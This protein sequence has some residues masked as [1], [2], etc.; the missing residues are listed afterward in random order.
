MRGGD[1]SLRSTSSRSVWW[2]RWS[3]NVRIGTGRAS[4]RNRPS[5]GGTGRA[6]GRGLSGG[7]N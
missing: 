4:G 5:V 6:S 2:Y 3:T 7:R 1:T